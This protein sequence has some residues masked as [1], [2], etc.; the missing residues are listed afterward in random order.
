MIMLLDRAPN[1]R[2]AVMRAGLAAMMLLLAGC[3]GSGGW[4]KP[5]VS[6]D[7][8]EADF[9]TCERQARSATARDAAIDADILASRGQDWQRTGTLAMKRDDMADS[10][11]GRAQ[12]VVA[13]CMAA[14][15]YT[16]AP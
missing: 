1:C 15:G 6:P 2:R 4:T 16:Q 14:K 12:Q 10:N 11:R 8:A 3:G 13:R 7:A 5:G 9:S